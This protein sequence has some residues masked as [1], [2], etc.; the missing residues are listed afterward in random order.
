MATT[1]DY[2]V[3]IIG[4]GFGGSVAA[5]RLVEKGY[6]VV[7]IECGKRFVPENMPKTNWDAKNFYWFPRLGMR[8][9]MRMSL[10]SDV[11]IVSGSAVG[12][13]S[14]VYA[15]TLYKP[16]DHYYNDSQWSHITDWKSELAPH[17]EQAERM[18]GVNATP[19]ESAADR[20][21]LKVADR[22]GVADT[23]H[24]TNVGVFFGEGEDPEGKTVPDPYFGGEGPARTGCIKCGECMTGCRHNAKN[25]L[26]KNYLYL[27]EKY[28]A[29]V[30]AD[31]MVVD[32]ESLGTVDG[33]E[34]YRIST[35]RPGA[36]LRHKRKTLTAGQVIFAA[37][38]LGTQKLLHKLKDSGRLPNIPDCMGTLTRTNSEAI[39]GAVGKPGNHDLED[40]SKG[41]AITSSIH[42]D[43]HTHIEP[44]VY[45]KGSNSTAMLM[46]P[47]VDGGG[48]MPRALRFLLTVLMHPVAFFRSTVVKGMS[49][50]GIILLVMQSLDNSLRTS[51]KKRRIFGEVL[52]TSP[53]HG[54]PNP[55]WIPKGNEAARHAADILGGDALGSIFEATLNVPTTAHIIGG[56]PI[57]D[58][59][60]SG[61]IDPYNRIYGHPSLHVTDG[62]AITANLGVNPSLSI[63]A[64]AERAVSMWPNRGD[65]DTRPALGDDYER[66]AIVEPNN[67]IVPRAAPGGLRRLPLVS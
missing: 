34:A 46:A 51:L 41:I 5:M 55:T 59:P 44:V 25:S 21:M 49:E 42:I 33:T 16:L 10:L 56:C 67:P 43:E 17:Y 7:V 50:R 3:A 28:G 14:V 8:G 22:M 66:I 20:L 32:V 13:G 9:M 52:T 19:F 54:E 53:G 12:G 37:G 38:S 35:D 65:A 62:S 1:L 63:T 47:I 58:S 29:E 36:V 23:Y 18:L 60:A 45:G 31:T 48:R 27:A 26:D 15:N 30:R 40:F 61:V 6:K 64:L 4:S 2:D 24:K 39:L 57:G 11:F